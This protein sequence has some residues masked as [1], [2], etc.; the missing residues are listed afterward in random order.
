[1]NSAIRLLFSPETS[2]T[3]GIW[4]STPWY[5]L[6]ALHG[7]TF[8]N[9]SGLSEGNLGDGRTGIIMTDFVVNLKAEG[10]MFD[11]L[12]VYTH[13]GE[14]TKNG[15]RFFHKVTRGA[16]LVALAEAGFLAFDYTAGKVTRV[17]ETFANALGLS[18][19]G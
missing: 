10:F 1:M 11:N 18:R 14:L 8:L 7:P 2:T 15:F 19:S 13:I 16:T 9:P 3:V 12:E 6:S 17:P 5:R 4:V